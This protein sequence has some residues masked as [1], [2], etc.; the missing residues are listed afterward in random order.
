MRRPGNKRGAVL[1]LARAA[2]KPETWHVSLLLAFPPN[3]QVLSS[4]SNA[5]PFPRGQEGGRIG[6][7]HDR[8]DTDGNDNAVEVSE[9]NIAESCRQNIESPQQREECLTASRWPASS[10]QVMREPK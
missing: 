6:R 3:K 7:L 2:I 5:D 1:R 8:R 9:R 10:F 4:R